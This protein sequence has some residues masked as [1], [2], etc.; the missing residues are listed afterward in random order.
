MRKVVCENLRD[1]NIFTI[2][3]K[4]FQN[5]QNYLWGSSRSNL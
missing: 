4:G 3:N 5:A 1:N 2:I